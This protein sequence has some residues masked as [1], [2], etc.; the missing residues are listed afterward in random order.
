[1]IDGQW[2]AARALIGWSQS[3]LAQKIGS[4]VLTIKRMET[5]GQKVSDEMRDRAKSALEDAG[6]E[7]TNGGQPGVRIKAKQ[8]AISDEAAIGDDPE[9]KGDPYIGSPQ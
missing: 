9:A 8:P 6:V 7:F 4:S 3:D 1:M 5:A 2:R